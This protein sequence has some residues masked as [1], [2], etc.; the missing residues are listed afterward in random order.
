MKDRNYNETRLAEIIE[1]IHVETLRGDGTEK[2]PVRI[3]HQY[4]AKDGTL[5]AEKDE[6]NH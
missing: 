2:N 4:W 5:L 1:V 3:I 6:I